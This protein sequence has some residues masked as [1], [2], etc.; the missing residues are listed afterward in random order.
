VFD[1]EKAL[2]NAYT[3]IRRYDKQ[4]HFIKYSDRGIEDDEE[5]YRFVDQYMEAKEAI[6][7]DLTSLA[8]EAHQ[9]K[10]V[11]LKQVMKKYDGKSYVKMKRDSLVLDFSK[12]EQFLQDNGNKAIQKF[13]AELQSLLEQKSG[14]GNLIKKELK[15][16]AVGRILDD[17]LKEKNLKGS[18]KG[19]IHDEIQVYNTEIDM[20]KIYSKEI[21]K[22]LADSSHA[23]ITICKTTP[24]FFIDH[25]MPTI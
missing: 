25:P 6:G 24:F 22:A 19:F 4:Y 9:L 5:L 3:T 15:K 8:Y 1:V 17:K 13:I 7:L 12:S 2:A 14:S 10:T 21:E 20:I 23:K 16:R 18:I 11:F